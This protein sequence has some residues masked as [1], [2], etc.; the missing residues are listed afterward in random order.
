MD[1]E[2]TNKSREALNAA[3]TRAV[4]EGNPD[5]T[6]AHLLLALLSGTENENVLDLLTAVGADPQEV[7][8]GAGRLV[9]TLPKVQGSTVAP[10]QANRDLLAVIA[11]AAQ[12]AK[13][14]GDAYIS[15]EHLLIGIAVKGGPA[16]EL[17]AGQGAKA[18]ALLSAFETARRAARDQ[19]G[20]GRHV[21]GAGEVRHRLHRGRP[22]GQARPGD[23]P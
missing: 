14:L 7:R 3:N 9:E 11:D 21:Q 22:G 4:A 23:R 13:E 18:K 17:L 2:L 1:A 10:P 8:T 19:P 6:P 12:R 15:T 20:P 5:L 16:A